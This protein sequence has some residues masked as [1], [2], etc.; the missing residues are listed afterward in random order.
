MKTYHTELG[1]EGERERERSYIQYNEKKDN[2]IGLIWR[3]NCL[4]IPV[5]EEEIKL[6][7]RR[8]RTKAGT[9]LF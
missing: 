4:P 6:K 3:I 7:K 2:W 5:I 9:R 8:R 1:R